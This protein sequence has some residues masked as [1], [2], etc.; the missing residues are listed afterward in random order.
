[1]INPRAITLESLK[2]MPRLGG[3]TVAEDRVITEALDG[4]PDLMQQ[5]AELADVIAT[6]EKITMLEAKAIIE[7]YGGTLE[8]AA[9]EIAS[10][11]QG[12]ILAYQAKARENGYRMMDAAVTALILS[13]G[14]EDGNGIPGW[15]VGH[16][17]RL[18]RDVYLEVWNI[19][20]AELNTENIKPEPMTE[21]SLGKHST[22][23][24]KRS[25]TGTKHSGS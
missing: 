24:A 8:P 14:G 19:A 16:T 2:S 1:M 18:M 11:H 5:L 12:G 13:R 7:Q 17:H 23:P 3:L 10:R 25:R 6:T 20:N 22:A 21:E 9:Q 15:T 4:S